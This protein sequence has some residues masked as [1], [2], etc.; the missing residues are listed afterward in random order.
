[1]HCRRFSTRAAHSPIAHSIGSPERGAALIVALMVFAL[2]TALIVAM[3]SD[4]L[5]LYQR[6]A[7]IFLAEQG[8][9]Y[10]RGAEALA[11]F[12]L[13]ADYDLQDAANP[14]DD[15]Q[16][17]WAQP[18]TPYP[19]EEGGWLAGELEDLQGRFNLNWLTKQPA[20]CAVV[21]R[22][23]V[24]QA[25]FIRLL[26]ALDEP[27]V[28]QREAIAITHALTDW[29][30]G[31]NEVA[32]DG[33]EDDFYV[34]LT[35]PY[36]TANR[37]M[38]SVSELLAVRGISPELY[39]AL[40][41]M[42]TVWPSQPEPLNIH[43]AN[44]TVLRSIGVDEGLLPL[45]K[46]DADALVEYREE[47]GFVDL[48]NFLGQPAFIDAAGQMACMQNLLGQNS[49]YFLLR[50][51]VEVAGKNMRLY[52]VLQREDRRINTLLRVSGSL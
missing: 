9:A 12:A 25:Q 29:L 14:R 42:V 31:D 5:R 6:G 33:A 34:G 36:R 52:S 48:Q 37:V 35:P 13:L 10:L 11:S 39:A 4:F 17:I 49:S 16:E 18:A 32:L 2:C 50:A 3:K 23:S 47:N 28:D 40:K 27:Q 15:L 24:G 45:T 20:G 30:D 38:G 41:S 7:N 22:F 46:S 1:M 43:T 44:A 8:Q 21:K 26:I 51:R 19:L